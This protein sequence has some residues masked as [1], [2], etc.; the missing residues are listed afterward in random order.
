M[1]DGREQAEWCLVSKLKDIL[2]H[3]SD[4]ADQLTIFISPQSIINSRPGSTCRGHKQEE[5]LSDT[6]PTRIDWAVREL[7]LD[8][9]RTSEG[10]LFGGYL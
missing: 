3:N 4:P 7:Q 9:L 5:Q 8:M 1:G 2:G 10:P 6:I